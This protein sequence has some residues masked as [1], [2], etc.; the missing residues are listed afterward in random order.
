[1]VAHRNAVDLQ[2]EERR[3]RV[4]PASSAV[5]ATRRLRPC[6]LRKACGQSRGMAS[7]VANRCIGDEA[8]CAGSRARYCSGPLTKQGRRLCKT[9]LLT[10]C[11]GSH[12]QLKVL[13]LHERC[14][15]VLMCRQHVSS[16]VFHSQTTAGGKQSSTC[17]GDSCIS[18]SSVVKS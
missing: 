8:L 2:Q 16:P 18:R 17:R 10:N 5:G 14:C 13:P 4:P 6:L 12:A 3:V 9:G 15:C 1:M 7:Y 11:P